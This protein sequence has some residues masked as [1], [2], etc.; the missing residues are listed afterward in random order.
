VLRQTPAILALLSAFFAAGCGSHPEPAA[1]GLPA[2]FRDEL[3]ARV[4]VPTALAWLPDGRMLVASQSGVVR[5]AERSGGLARRPALDLSRRVCVERERGMTGIAADPAFERTRFV[6]VYY[7]FKKFGSCAIESPKSPVNRLSRFVMRPDGTLDPGT[8]FPLVDN[9]PSYGA[10]H[11]AGDVKFGK[12]G[13]LYVSIGDGG[14]DYARRTETSERNRA[15]RDRN[16][17]LGKVLRLTTRGGPAPGNPFRGRGTAP[18][19]R[20]GV[21]ASGT[22]CRETYVWGL[23]N[24]F[25]IAFDGDAP[26]VRLFINEVGQVAWEEVDE[27]T[28]GADYGWPLRE[29]PCPQAGRVRCAPAPPS[30]TDP[31]FAYAHRHGCSAITA[32]AFVPAGAWPRRFDGD[33]LFADLTCTEIRSLSGSPE[34]SATVGRFYTGQ[35]APGVVA[36]AFHGHDLYYAAYFTGEVRRIRYAGG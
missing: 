27:A 25:R 7:T 23:R 31:L 15:A 34:R 13:Y 10:T 8:E 30:M 6:Y 19:A 21:A 36:M 33:Y 2:G 24:P 4:S 32:G 9:V 17:L 12:D 1:D 29:G 3:V 11:N 28:P 5:L 26:G 35:G 16:V 20:V 14:R 18:C 22:L